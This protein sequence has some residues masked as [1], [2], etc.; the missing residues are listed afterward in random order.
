MISTFTGY[1]LVVEDNGDVITEKYFEK[2]Y[3]Q[4][5]DD[6]TTASK[7][8]EHL[9]S[10]S[11]ES[12][13]VSDV[14]L[15]IFLSGGIDS[16][17]ITALA[18]QHY[19]GRL[20]T[21]SAGFDFEKGINELPKARLVS[22]VFDTNH[23][24]LH[25]K[26]GELPHLIEE[27]VSHHDK[28]FSDAANIPLYLLSKELNGDPKV[29]LQGDGGD[30]FFGGYYRYAR[31]QKLNLWRALSPI[32]KFS[33]TI[34]PGSKFLSRVNRNV[35]ALSER[36]EALMMARLLSQEPANRDPLTLLTK[37]AQLAT[38]NYS[39]F[40]RYQELLKS[41]R[42]SWMGIVDKMMWLDTQIILPD[43]YFEK[44]DRATMANSIEVRVPMIDNELT[45]YVSSLPAHYKL[46]NGSGKYVLKKAL[47]EV[48][49]HEILYGPKTGFSVPFQYWLR[50]SL[51]DFAYS[52]IMS[53]NF[54]SHDIVGEDVLRELLQDH[55]NNRSDN[56]FL[57]YKL[58]NFALWL[59]RYSV[60]VH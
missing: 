31:L 15:G 29:I 46:R 12:Q 9:L 14:P 38:A 24:E 4:S 22:R 23:H 13:L 55:R 39:P 52:N 51:Y 5:N 53:D 45:S 30:E 27:L 57:I 35:S 26:G 2:T 41:N 18:S 36:D 32:V 1:Y 40:F 60:T 7:K 16:S 58:L 20:D 28:P 48:L 8:I 17:A 34:F 44:V 25:I 42:N 6:F 3:R 43:L 56:G 11:V 33:S 49:P 37:E 50:T 21:Y 54:L 10:K 59:D 47:E 19:S